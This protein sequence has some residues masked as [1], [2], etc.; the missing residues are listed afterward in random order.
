MQLPPFAPIEELFPDW[1]DARI[2]VL[3]ALP[4]R[5]EMAFFDGH[6]LATDY[7]WV[8]DLLIDAPDDL[9]MQS[10]L[11]IRF[12]QMARAIQPL[13]EMADIT[14]Y[15]GKPMTADTLA[16]VNLAIA[17]V[18]RKLKLMGEPTMLE[19]VRHI[20]GLEPVLATINHTLH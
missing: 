10:L 3:S 6:V 2:H 13:L 20:L 8:T 1:S 15:V 5:I 9:L 16:G 14:G 19:V 18:D 4:Q 11:R 7:R 17:E 12:S